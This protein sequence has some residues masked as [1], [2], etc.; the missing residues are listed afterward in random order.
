MAG[1]SQS[2]SSA[3]LEAA[4]RKG[5]GEP[6]VAFAYPRRSTGGCFTIFLQMV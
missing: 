6:P 5:F 4:R 2:W 3:S 1:S